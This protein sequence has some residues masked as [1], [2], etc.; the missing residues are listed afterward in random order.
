MN[1]VFASVSAPA[2]PQPRAASTYSTRLP[3]ITR[4]PTEAAASSSSRMACSDAPRRLRRST[5]TATS[6]APRSASVSQ[7]V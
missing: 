6:G 7:Y 2:A 5:K 4:T 3:S 1:R